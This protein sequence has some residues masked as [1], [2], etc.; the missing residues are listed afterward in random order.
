MWKSVFFIMLFGMAMAATLSAAMV[1]GH[2]GK[3]SVIDRVAGSVA[4]GVGQI[5]NSGPALDK[6]LSKIDL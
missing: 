4:R 5:E 3:K 2:S 1:E 6:V